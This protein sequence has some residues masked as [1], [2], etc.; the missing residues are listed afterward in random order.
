M[1]TTRGIDIVRSLAEQRLS[2]GDASARF[3]DVCTIEVRAHRTP[4]Q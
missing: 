4:L 2:N 3:M 1:S